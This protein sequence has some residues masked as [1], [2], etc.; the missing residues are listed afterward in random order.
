MSRITANG[1]FIVVD[2][3]NDFCPGG[4]LEVKEGDRVVPVVNEL[5]PH[6]RHNVFTRDWHP[7][8]HCSF[9][10]DPQFVDMSWPPHCIAGTPGAEF[11]PD[12]HVPED[13]IH[14]LK[15]TEPETESYSDF[16]NTGLA[17]RLRSE[18]V[19]HVYIAGLATDYCVKSTALD[20]I[21]AGFEATVIQ[22]A[23][24]AVDVPPG[25]GDRALEEMRRAGVK[26]TTSKD[27]LT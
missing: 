22:D 27:I 23:V 9:S 20:A 19:T 16:H 7:E 17:E 6:F 10:E 2:V 26:M 15:A 1:A 25:N 8:N 14:V 3:Q 5:T 21:E 24:R 18:G 12:L 4:A 11:H 13:A